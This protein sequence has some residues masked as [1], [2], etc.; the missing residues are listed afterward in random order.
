MNYKH[1]SQIERYQIASLMKAQHSITQIASLIGRHKSTI[2][3]E[4]RRNAGSRGYRP[5]QACEK[6]VER[7]KHS[8]NAYTAEPRVKEQAAALLRLQWSPEQVASKLPV[9][10]ETPDQHVYADKTGCDNLWRKMCG[11]KQKRILYAGWRDRRGQIPNCGPLSKRPAHLEGRE[12]PNHWERDT[13]IGAN[14]KQAIVTVVE[15]KSGY[16]VIAKVSNKTADLAGTTIIRE[17]R[18]SE[19]RSKTP[20]YDNDNG[21]CGHALADGAL[22]S[23][24]YLTRLFASGERGSNADLEFCQNFIGLL[25][26]YVLN[27]CQLK[28]IN[29]EEIK[30]IENRLNNRL[31]QRLEFRMPAEAVYQSSY[32]IAVRV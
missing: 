31:R 8:R 11:Q 1:L 17:P 24:G 30:S 27:K 26:Q 28:D 3:R 10:H 32:R 29:F 16:A 25:L 13:V 14:H 18:P 21:T 23:T 7:S 15:R 20:T 22:R 9:S 19:A 4:L 5:K 2:S 6:A 12:Q